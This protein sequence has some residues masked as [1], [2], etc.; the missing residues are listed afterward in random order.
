VKY[1]WSN[2]LRF[3]FLCAALPLMTSMGRASTIVTLTDG[4]AIFEIDPTSPAGMS[5]WSFGGGAN[6]MPQ[7][8]F[9]FRT[10]AT[11]FASQGALQSIDS[12][13][14]PVVTPI[15]PGDVDIKFGNSSS[16]ISTDMF[17]MLAD[18]EPASLSEQVKWT[19]NTS[20]TLYLTIFQYVHFQF[21]PGADSLT[22]PTTHSAGQNGANGASD[23]SVSPFTTPGGLV[24]SEAALAS[25]LLNALTDGATSSSFN[26]NN[27]SSASG[28]TATAF[29][30]QIPL[31]ANGSFILSINEN[32]TPATAPEPGPGL[33]IAAGALALY[34]G[35][36]FRK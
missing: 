36:R 35:R 22:L 29:E 16:P 12:I 25:T 1:L 14:N 21:S 32:V 5:S 11:G 20:S 34:A 28:D 8:W 10:S 15:D 17:L 18:G 7:Q 30:W 31:A 13:G 3:I 24:G 33:L 27:S 4:T 23:V 9:W 26:V 2:F 6:I 19:N